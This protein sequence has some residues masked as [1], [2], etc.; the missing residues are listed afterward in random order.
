MPSS[1]QSAPISPIDNAITV[2]Y[3]RTLIEF[4]T[5]YIMQSIKYN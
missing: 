5:C 3:I 4:L 2:P 1:A